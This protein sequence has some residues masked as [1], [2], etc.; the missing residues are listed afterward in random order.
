MEVIT[1]QH[2]PIKDN[3]GDTGKDIGYYWAGVKLEIGTAYGKWAPI[4]GPA[5]LG[6]VWKATGVQGWIE[7]AHTRPTSFE[8]QK[9]LLVIRAD[10][11][12]SMTRIE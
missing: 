12:Y 9:Y 8:E 1:I 11:T 3:A 7:V 5:G 6:P 10:G 2:G 4:T